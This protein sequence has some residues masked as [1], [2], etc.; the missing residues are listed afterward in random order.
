M[1]KIKNGIESLKKLFNVKEDEVQMVEQSVFIDDKFTYY[2]KNKHCMFYDGT[3][4]KIK[5]KG[6]EEIKIPL[7]SKRVV[8]YLNFAA[9]EL[10][11]LNTPYHF[12]VVYDQEYNYFYLA[13]L[14]FS[15]KE[16]FKNFPEN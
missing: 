1:K 9:Q 2:D 3:C 14:N 7:E 10:N 15:E 13:I 8:K 16:L 11:K 12:G 5:K 4:L 6:Q